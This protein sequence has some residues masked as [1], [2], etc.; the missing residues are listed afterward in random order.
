VVNRWEQ[1]CW[2]AAL[3]DAAPVMRGEPCPV[4]GDATREGSGPCSEACEVLAGRA[5][6]R[7][8]QADDWSEDDITDDDDVE[9][10]DRWAMEARG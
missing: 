5:E 4:C 6:R 9:D 2:D 1:V 8:D 7:A 10:F 3:D